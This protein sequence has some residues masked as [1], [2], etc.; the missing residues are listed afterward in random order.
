MAVALAPEDVDRF[1]ELAHAENLEATPVAVVT[2]SGR[3]RMTW[4]GD[5]IVDV[6]REF[7]ASNGARKHMNVHV[8]EGG[9]LHSRLAGQHARRAPER[10]GHRP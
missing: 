6:S 3:V 9:E 10:S 7:L 1:I 2:D 4:R 5:T 8:E